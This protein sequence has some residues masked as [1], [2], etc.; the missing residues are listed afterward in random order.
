MTHRIFPRTV[1]PRS[2]PRCPFVA[3]G[4]PQGV[5]HH[6]SLAGCDQPIH[7]RRSRMADPDRQCSARL[8]TDARH[9]VTHRAEQRLL[10]PASRQAVRP[11]EPCQRS[12]RAGQDGLHR[13]GGRAGGGCRT[14]CV[15]GCRRAASAP[16]GATEPAAGISCRRPTAA[17][18]LG[19]AATGLVHRCA[20]ALR[21]PALL[22]RSPKGRGAAWCDAPGGHGVSD[23]LEQAPSEAPRGPK[24][25]I[26]RVGHA[27]WAVGNCDPQGSGRTWPPDRHQPPAVAG[28][29]P[30]TARQNRG[31]TPRQPSSRTALC[32]VTIGSGQ[33][34]GFHAIPMN[35]DATIHTGNQDLKSQPIWKQN[36]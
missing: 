19:G 7:G 8:D 33:E 5:D 6:S 17:C 16:Q 23:R 20:H 21:G 4:Q 25:A 2:S 11:V 15:P 12:V 27:T 30:C 35:P 32:H 3:A 18:V 29:A 34:V 22:R 10:R 36:S 31:E 1:G 26:R 13:R 9:L 28:A 14:R 24:P